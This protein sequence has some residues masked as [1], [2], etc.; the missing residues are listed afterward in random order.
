MKLRY[1]VIGVCIL[2]DSLKAD[3]KQT[4]SCGKNK[5]YNTYI[6]KVKCIYY[7]NPIISAAKFPFDERNFMKKGSRIVNG[8]DPSQPLPYQLSIT[9]EHRRSL[10]DSRTVKHHFCGAVL[11]T[12]K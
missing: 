5:I 8:F 6:L 11:I 7:S 2:L 1:I 12:K 3:I 10:S 9:R 4:D